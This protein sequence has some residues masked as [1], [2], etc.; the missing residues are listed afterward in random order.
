METPIVLVQ[1]AVRNLPRLEAEES[2]LAATRASVGSGWMKRDDARA[3]TTRWER[4]AHPVRHR[5]RRS[6]TNLGALAQMGFG[7]ARVPVT[8][9]PEGPA[10]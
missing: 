9:R 7:V 10:S 5:G 8:S 3:I 1:A 6:P 4:V 2:L